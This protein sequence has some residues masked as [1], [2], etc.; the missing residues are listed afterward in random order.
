MKKELLVIESRAYKTTFWDD[1]TIT[2]DGK[3][4]ASTSWSAFATEKD[5]DNYFKLQT[6]S[7]VSNIMWAVKNRKED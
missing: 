1:K 2:T 6:P 4:G 3:N 5:L 7:W